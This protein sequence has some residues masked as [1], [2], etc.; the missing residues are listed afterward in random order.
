[1]FNPFLN[2]VVD[3]H[4]SC[5]SS[6]L[7]S[8]ICRCQNWAHRNQADTIIRQGSALVVDQISAESGQVGR[9][10]ARSGRVLAG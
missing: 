3:L 8:E 2:D 4:E 5:L 7:S 10:P 9:I 6:Q 1:M